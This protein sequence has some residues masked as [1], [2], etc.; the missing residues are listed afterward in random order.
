[1]WSAIGIPPL[2]IISL[3]LADWTAGTDLGVFST[4]LQL[5]IETLMPGGSDIILL[6]DPPSAPSVAS[7]ASQDA[8]VHEIALAAAAHNLIF[9]DIYSLWAALLV[10]EMATSKWWHDWSQAPRT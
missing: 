8:Y 1:M 6:S 2:T 7:K 9:I 3:G 10:A 5:L 4:R